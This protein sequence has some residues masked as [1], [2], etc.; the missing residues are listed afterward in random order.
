MK[1]ALLLGVS[2]Y[3]HPIRSLPGCKNDLELME[4]LLKSTGDFHD[5]LS[6]LSD[7]HPTLQVKNRIAEWIESYKAENVDEVFVYY[8]GHGLFLDGEFYFPLSDYKDEIR[9]Q[10]SI[11]NSELDNWVKEMK[12]EL[13]VK[14]V[15]ACNSGVLYVKS[16][17]DDLVKYLN[18]ARDAFN[19]VIFMFSSTTE[20]SSFL[21]EKYS[22]FT[23]AYFD[24]VVGSQDD[25]VRYRHIM[26]YVT[27]AFSRLSL[28]GRQTPTFVT[29]GF[30]NEVFCTMT[31]DVREKVADQL[32]AKET[33]SSE[34]TGSFLKQMA[35]AAS[36]RLPTKE[37]A[38]DTLTHLHNGLKTYEYSEELRELF[39]VTTEDI[40]I[41]RLPLREE[42]GLMLS[43]VSHEFFARPTYRTVYDDAISAMLA[44]QNS[45]MGFRRDE[46]TRS[47]GR[48]VLSGFE[49]TTQLPFEALVVNARRKYE[50]LSSG[51]CAITYLVTRTHLRLLFF[52]TNHRNTDWDESE[53][54]L[55]TYWRISD[56]ELIDTQAAIQAGIQVLAG[57]DEYVM[58]R[59]QS[60]FAQG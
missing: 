28:P 50:I 21:G 40:A 1:I 9:N 60:Q 55:S 14:V 34:G 2:E 51:Y 42:I 6:I 33:M 54:E 17:Q 25:T 22:Y 13:A 35:E 4:R 16:V 49:F 29:Q 11:T 44:S 10:T 57:F 18:A 15:D 59:V 45:I 26:D 48:E 7:Q 43:D 3:L 36:S 38:L 27:D 5:V 12:P 32:E 20:Q 46:E 8:T 52:Y 58:S 24:A 19:R 37:L 39:E 47:L 41:S 31:K 53:L 30:N 56:T 23:K